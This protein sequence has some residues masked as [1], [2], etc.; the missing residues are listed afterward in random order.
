[1]KW[2]EIQTP[3]KD[4]YVEHIICEGSRNHVLSYDYYGAKCNVENC[5]VNKWRKQRIENIE[6]EDA[7]RFMNPERDGWLENRCF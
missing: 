6:K 7:K 2:D 3:D 1:M 4:G 5:E